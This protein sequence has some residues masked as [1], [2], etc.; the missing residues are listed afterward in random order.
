MKQT[1]IDK[2]MSRKGLA[3]S[4]RIIALVMVSML[5]YYTNLI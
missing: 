4:F 2:F 3:S 1:F 5:I